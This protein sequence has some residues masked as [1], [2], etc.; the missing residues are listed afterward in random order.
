MKW[1]VCRTL[2]QAVT[3]PAVIRRLEADGWDP[4]DRFSMEF[5][6]AERMQA[7]S[8]KAVRVYYEGLPWFLFITSDILI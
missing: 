8:R 6:A 5:L 7:R 3:P 1:I 2:M 4:L